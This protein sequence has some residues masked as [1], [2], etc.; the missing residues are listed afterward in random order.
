MSIRDD[1]I[2]IAFAYFGDPYEWGGDG[3]GGIGGDDYDCSGFILH[4]LQETGIFPPNLDMTAQNIYNAYKDYAV[5]TA[6]KGCVGF[7][8][9]TP[10]QITHCVLIINSRACI[11]ANGGNVG[12]VSVER[13]NYHKKPMIAIVDPFQEI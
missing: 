7:Y 4:I 12:M 6:H 8:G 11:G 2:E 1:A 10:T 13:L 5:E 3:V 9:L